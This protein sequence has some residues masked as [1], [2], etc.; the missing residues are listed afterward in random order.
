MFSSP[1]TADRSESTFSTRRDFPGAGKIKGSIARLHLAW[2]RQRSGASAFLDL[3]KALSDGARADLNLPIMATAWVP[4][5]SLVELD[6]LIVERLG[7]GDIRILDPVG[8]YVAL[9][10]STTTFR[11]L[12]GLRVHT[13]FRHMAFLHT[14]FHDFSSASYE[15]KDSGAQIVH[16]H[17]RAFS[18]LYCQSMLGYYAQM[19]RLHG[20]RGILV[21][22]SQCQSL[23]A[24]SCIFDLVWKD[25]CD[26]PG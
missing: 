25:R 3:I 23:G 11:A 8:R 6:R 7:D 19:A 18:T 21:N 24:R 1:A 16:R 26:L 9:I 13:F 5:S 22:E 4:F 2:A 12:S 17:G 14:H 10:E 20:A 15:E